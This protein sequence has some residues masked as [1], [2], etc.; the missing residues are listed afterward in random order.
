MG[1]ALEDLREAKANVKRL[2]ERLTSYEQNLEL[3]DCSEKKDRN[4]IWVAIGDLG[5]WI[6]SFEGEKME[7]LLETDST[8][9][10]SDVISS[11]LSEVQEEMH[12][13]TD[14]KQKV[15]RRLEEMRESLHLKLQE[16]LCRVPFEKVSLQSM[17]Q[18]M[19]QEGM[20]PRRALLQ[21]ASPHGVPCRDVVVGVVPQNMQ[22]VPP[23]GTSPQTS[24]RGSTVGRA[25]TKYEATRITAAR[26]ASLAA[27]KDRCGAAT[28]ISPLLSLQVMVPQNTQSLVSEG[29]SK[30]RS[31]IATAGSAT[32]TSFTPWDAATTT[33]AVCESPMMQK[34]MTPPPQAPSRILSY[35]YQQAGLPQ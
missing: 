16:K 21:R 19:R 34:Q 17:P 20:A 15:L 1:A 26:S 33:N 9:Y 8:G 24:S 30:Q 29:V 7:K 6:K 13:A 28:S 18:R 10:G 23:H 31:P 11:R 22:K 3:C 2:D 5:S 12:N 4:D 35:K 14:R 27:S 32:I 25:A